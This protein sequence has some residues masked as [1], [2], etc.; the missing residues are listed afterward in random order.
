MSAGRDA[1]AGRS[2]A[3]AGWP[4]RAAPLWVGLAA[5]AVFTIGL[6]RPPE[7]DELY[8]V[9]A[10][11]GWLATG[12]L[13]IADGLYERTALYSMLIGLLF[14]R[15]GESLVVARLPSVAASAVLAAALF[16][17]AGPTTWGAVRVGSTELRLAAGALVVGAV[18][19]LV[20]GDRGTS[21]R[22]RWGLVA[23]G[24][25]AGGALGAGDRLP[26]AQPCRRAPAGR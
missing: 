12:E 24:G 10:A 7:F 8:H 23:A 25:A 5:L 21:A 20:A 11:R 4:L 3:V 19:G 14:E 17:A 15:L 18:L 1:L 6:D 22:V 13:R 16:A 2:A 9:L 26:G